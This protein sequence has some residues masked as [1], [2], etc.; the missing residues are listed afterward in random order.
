MSQ[1]ETKHLREA[2]R[3]AQGLLRLDECDVCGRFATWF[4]VAWYED[5]GDAHW[6]EDHCP[7]KTSMFMTPEEA[8][9]QLVWA[10]VRYNHADDILAYEKILEQLHEIERIRPENS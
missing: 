2:L 10:P 1:H 8:L 4:Q 7:D 6:C 9:R 3:L 5:E